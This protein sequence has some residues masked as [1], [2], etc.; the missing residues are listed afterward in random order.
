MTSMPH[1]TAPKAERG[2]IPL[3]GIMI[4]LTQ[5]GGF[6]CMVLSLEWESWGLDWVWR[7]SGDWDWGKSGV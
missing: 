5:G 6:W 2:W 1:P 3:S 7:R 4:I